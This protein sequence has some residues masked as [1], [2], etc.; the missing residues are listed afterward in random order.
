MAIL[1]IVLSA[2]A[3]LAGVVS[4]DL[5]RVNSAGPLG[6]LRTATFDADFAVNR[7]GLRRERAFE[8]A[9]Q[10]T[11]I[12]EPQP[13]FCAGTVNVSPNDTRLVSEA[14]EM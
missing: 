8:I 14:G 5:G 4:S 2:R 6:V 11:T 9:E 12:P 13:N 3:P 7:F 1:V 10:Q